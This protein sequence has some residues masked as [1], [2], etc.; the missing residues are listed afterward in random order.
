M[1][2]LPAVGLMV[3]LMVTG[4]GGKQTDKPAVKLTAS[5]DMAA[6][7][8]QP[9]LVIHIINESGHVLHIPD[10]RPLAGAKLAAAE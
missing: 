6:P 10:P 2:I 4:A 9:I 1:R 8:S 5:L 7:E 3:M